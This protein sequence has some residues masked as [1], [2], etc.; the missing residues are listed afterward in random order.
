MGTIGLLIG[1]TL[2]FTTVLIA[3]GVSNYKSK[4]RNRINKIIQNK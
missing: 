4:K 1:I 2:G 3:I